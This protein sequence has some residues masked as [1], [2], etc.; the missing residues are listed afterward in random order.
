MTVINDLINNELSDNSSNNPLYIS[1]RDKDVTYKNM[2]LVSKIKSI[3]EIHIQVMNYN[4]TPI[5]NMYWLEK[6]ELDLS[7]RLSSMFFRVDGLTACSS[8]LLYGR[9]KTPL[10]SLKKLT[11]LKELRI[12]GI[13]SFGD[14]KYMKNLETLVIRHGLYKENF[15]DLIEAIYGL[16]LKYLNINGNF[17]TI[18]DEMAY[19]ISQI[20]TL[21]FLVM[22]KGYTEVGLKYLSNLKNLKE[23]QFEFGYQYIKDFT[24]LELMEIS[25]NNTDPKSL[26]SDLDGIQNLPNLTS[27]D[28]DY[29]LKLNKKAAYNIGRSTSIKNI[30][31]FKYDSDIL[32]G[33]CNLKLD[34]IHINNPVI[35]NPA[36]NNHGNT[37]KVFEEYSFQNSIL[38]NTINTVILEY[39]EIFD[40]DIYGVTLIP[41]LKTLTLSNC[42]VTNEIF[43]IIGKNCP[44]LSELSVTQIN[45]Y[46]Y[47]GYENKLYNQNFKLGGK[48]LRYLSNFIYPN[49]ICLEMINFEFERYDFNYFKY[50]KMPSLTYLT[51][52]RSNGLFADELKILADTPLGKNLKFLDID[53]CPMHGNDWASVENIFPKNF[54]L[55]YR[56]KEDYYDDDYDDP[57]NDR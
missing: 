22:P 51:L 50:F 41:N 48:A 19:L 24:G 52:S 30:K 56:T 4:M 32:K 29:D 47:N 12:E 13:F 49:L 44:N 55:I 18:N 17:I 2:I 10:I 53:G 11:N 54:E 9:S 35:N 20:R 33:F 7:N 5:L 21:E 8:E 38:F 25:C 1:Y 3:K 15:Y 57:Y 31:Y 23:Y 40:N 42:T 28:F 45:A 6:I 46:N 34:K 16:N 39:L 14:L 27:V 36:K 43:K 37:L 26:D